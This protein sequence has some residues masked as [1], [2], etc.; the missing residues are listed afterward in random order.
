[1][2]YNVTLSLLNRLANI[3]AISCMKDETK[4]LSTAF[5]CGFYIEK[6]E[7][8]ADTNILQQ[9]QGLTIVKM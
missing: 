7:S 3:Y 1:M 4:Q 9:Y 2:K 5:L 6:Q 8:S